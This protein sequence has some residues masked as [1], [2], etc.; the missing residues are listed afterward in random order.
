MTA[1]SGRS[2]AGNYEV[3]I[4]QDPVKGSFSGGAIAGFPINT[5]GKD[6]SFSV[7]VDG[8]SAASITLPTDKIYASGAELAA[9]IQS[10]INLDSEIKAARVGVQVSFD[11]NTNQLQ[12]T[13]N[14]Y[15]AASV[16]SFATVGADMTDLGISAGVGVAGQDVAG[17]VDGVAAFGFGNVLLPAIGS[18]AEGL[19][20]MITPGATSGSIGFS[21]GFAGQMDTLINDFLKTSGLIKARETNINDKIDD[22]KDNTEALDRRSEAYRLRLQ[23]QFTAMEAIV[24]SLNTTGSFLDGILDRLPFTSKNN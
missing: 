24:R 6:Y 16:V 14:A 8:V 23:S 3:V 2:T 22:V 15:G 19:S 11:I 10:L 5:T 13:S 4:T 1:F 17:T 12:F 21:R 7:N 18:K 20:M 9:D